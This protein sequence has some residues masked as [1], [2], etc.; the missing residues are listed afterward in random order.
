MQWLQFILQQLTI[1]KEDN[2]KKQIKAFYPKYESNSHLSVRN[3]QL[4]YTRS[5]SF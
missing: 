4:I 2:L 1:C 3:N 5:V